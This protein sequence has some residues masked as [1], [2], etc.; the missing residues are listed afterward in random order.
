MN[1]LLSQSF[2]SRIETHPVTDLEAGGGGTEM[3]IHL[4]SSGFLSK[5]EKEEEARFF[6]EVEILKREMEKI[7]QLLSKLQESNE[8]SRTVTS[9]QSM[10]LLRDR[11][12]SHIA[13]VLKTAKLIKSKLEALD[14]ANKEN[15]LIPGC[16]QGSTADRTRLTITNSLRKALK[17]LMDDFQALRQKMSFEYRETVERRF[18]TVTGEKASEETIDHMIESGESET[19]LQKAVREQGRGQI[20]ETIKEI[21]ERHDAVKEIEKNL[22]ELHQIFMDMAVL[23]EAQGHQIDNIEAAVKGATSFVRRGTDQLQT[24]KKL[25]RNSRKFTCIA[26][27]ILLIIILVVVVPILVKLLRKNSSS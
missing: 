13:E 2:R 27:I 20:I 23:V 21:K 3:S 24:A 17:A 14:K 16:E 12:D 1:D 11:M 9:A 15:R 10:K 26:I 5:R 4:T 25:Q 6:E 18:F 7:M 19:F 8:E 22:L